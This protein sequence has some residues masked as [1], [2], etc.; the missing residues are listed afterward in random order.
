VFTTLCSRR[1]LTSLRVAFY[2]RWRAL[3]IIWLDKCVREH[4]ISCRTLPTTPTPTQPSRCHSYLPRRSWHSLVPCFEL[5]GTRKR[6]IIQPGFEIRCPERRFQWVYGLIR[7]W[8]LQTRKTPDAPTRD[9]YI[10]LRFHSLWAAGL[11]LGV[12]I[13]GHPRA[14]LRWVQMTILKSLP[15]SGRLTCPSATRQPPVV[16]LS[17]ISTRP[18]LYCFTK[19]DEHYAGCGQ[20]F[21]EATPTR[22][23]LQLY[24]VRVEGIPEY[25][26]SSEK[27]AVIKRTQP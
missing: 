15:V 22:N 26:R 1:L 16:S 23:P 9:A 8:L 3:A 13:I 2:S 20:R 7:S 5:F 18:F 24:S 12:R 14:Y 11:G 19:K 25:R 10:F 4:V 21:R 27:C 17:R 6:F